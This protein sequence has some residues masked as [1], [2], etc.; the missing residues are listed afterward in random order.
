MPVAVP[1][2]LDL[3]VLAHLAQLVERDLAGRGLQGQARDGVADR[4]AVGGAGLAHGG[5]RHLGR[6]VAG[7]RHHVDLVAGLLLEGGDEGLGL[8]LIGIAV[9][10]GGDDGAL[11]RGAG[12]LDELLGVVTLLADDR[13]VDAGGA[14][15]ADQRAG[16]E[17][18]ARGVDHFRIVGLDLGD[19]G[20]ELPVLDGVFVLGHDGDAELAGSFLEAGGQRLAEVVLKRDHHG[21]LFAQDGAGQLGAGAALDLADE[22][23]AEHEVAA[24]GDPRMHRVGG[25]VGDAVG[26]KDA[27]G[28]PGGARIAAGDGDV[29]LVLGGQLGG[30]RHRFLRRGLIVVDQKLDRLAV[31]AALG[32]GLLD[33]QF[34]AGQRRLAVRRGEAGQRHV[35][36]DLDGVGLRRAAH[37][38][39]G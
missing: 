1:D 21:A 28:G 36:P 23:G 10:R 3:D 13:H 33:G 5:D 6:G 19:D 39:A 27:G 9:E 8:G 35:E 7:G 20:A 34:G 31:D 24:A 12:D 37:K 38:R 4:L 22:G 16:G 11:G 25:D 30:D 26:L 17:E 2:H 14:Q 15:L 32:V 29:H 18:V